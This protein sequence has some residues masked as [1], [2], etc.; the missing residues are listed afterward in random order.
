MTTRDLSRTPV[1]SGRTQET[2]QLAGV[3]AR[4]FEDDPVST[5]APKADRMRSAP[6]SPK[7]FG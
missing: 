6:S 7:K 3:L 5:F 4:A 2:G 1:R